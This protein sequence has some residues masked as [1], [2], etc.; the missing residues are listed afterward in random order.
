M[1]YGRTQGQVHELGRFL[2]LSMT[3]GLNILDNAV[4]KPLLSRRTV[5]SGAS[6]A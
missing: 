5:Q 4:T 2:A 6:A 3:Q 1:A